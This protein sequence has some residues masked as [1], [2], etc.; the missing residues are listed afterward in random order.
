MAGFLSTSLALP[1]GAVPGWAFE[2][3]GNG[4][5]LKTNRERR[6]A[7]CSPRVTLTRN[8]GHRSVGSIQRRS[9]LQDNVQRESEVIEHST[10][11]VPSTQEKSNC[12]Y[13]LIRD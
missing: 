4:L 3:S 10:I 11:E 9:R 12:D 6:S 7:N 13:L 8:K 5:V 1:L 2:S